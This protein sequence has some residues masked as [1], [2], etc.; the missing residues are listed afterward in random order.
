MSAT[1]TVDG[2]VGTV[3]GNE[4]TVDENEGTVDENVGTVD[5]QPPQHADPPG[6]RRSRVVALRAAHCDDGG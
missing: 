2:D 1:A 5:G 4:G 3:D 6:T